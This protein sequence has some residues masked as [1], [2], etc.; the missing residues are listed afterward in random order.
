[1]A[2]G[3][4]VNSAPFRT[5]ILL[6]SVL[7]AVAC[8]TPFGI[9]HELQPGQNL[10]RL[11]VAYDVPV[12]KLLR[13]NR[14]NDPKKIQPGR[15]IFI[16]GAR[17]VK[18]VGSAGSSQPTASAARSAKAPPR[19]STTDE[20]VRMPAAKSGSTRKSNWD[21]GDAPQLVWPVQGTL[22]SSFGSRDGGDHDGID[23]SASPGTPI[24]A[25]ADGRVIYSGS[26]ISGYGN[27]VIVKHSGSWAT[28]Y[29]HNKV[30]LVEKGA[31]V[32]QGQKI[33]EVGQTGRASGPH[34]HFEVRF[35]KGAR[36]PL[37]YLPGNS[38][39]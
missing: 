39:S 1:M 29:A 30:N 38:P 16:P 25:A 23:I 4:Q 28:V 11:S 7:S 21:G 32:S 20:R 18:Q 36:D 26:G 17:S 9:Y 10:Y 12:D 34:L 35:G 6:L 8:G 13:I 3:L 31:F 33:A 5:T 14:I 22:T 24:Y 37:K 15:R 2:A 19:S 27:L